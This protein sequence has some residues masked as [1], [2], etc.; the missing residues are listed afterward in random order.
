MNKKIFKTLR[1]LLAE[2]KFK[3]KP[4]MLCMWS[5]CLQNVVA[6]EFVD[7]Y[8]CNSCSITYHA[9][10]HGSSTVNEKSRSG[11]VSG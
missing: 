9:K 10:A 1:N 2:S 8:T 4:S 6:T 5:D 3:E 11:D 7:V